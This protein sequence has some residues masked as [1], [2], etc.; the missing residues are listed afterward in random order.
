MACLQM[1]AFIKRTGQRTLRFFLPFSLTGLHLLLSDPLSAQTQNLRTIVVQPG[2][3]VR[4]LAE[5][6]LGDANLWEEILKTNQLRSASEVRS[7]MELKIPYDAVQL[8]KRQL[9]AASQ[10]IERATDAGA[11]VYAADSIQQAILFYDQA[12]AN[13]KSGEWEKSFKLAQAAMNK[14]ENAFQAT[15]ERRNTTGVAVLTD[16]KGTVESRFPTDNLWK[17]APLLSELTESEMV[18]TLSRSFAEVSFH[19]ESR[20]RLNENS[21]AMIEKMRVDL[22]EQKKQSSVTL[23]A[24]NAFALLN[25]NQKRKKFDFAISGVSTKVNSRNFWVQ[26]DEQVT[27]LANY[28]GEI[29]ITSQ[30][31]TVVVGENQGALVAANQKPT[32]PS[33]L[34]PSPSLQSPAN[35]TT[36]FNDQITLTWTAIEGAVNYWVVISR[37]KS[38][39]NVVVNVSSMKDHVFAISLSEE[40]YYYWRV[41]AI[42]R[43]GFPSP[44]SV[45]GFFNMLI[46]RQAPFVQ[47]DQPAE[48]AIFRES[49]VAVTGEVEKGAS[50]SLNGKS[51]PV[52]PE[53]AFNWQHAL[54][55]GVNELNLE[56]KDAAGNVTQQRRRVTYAADAKVA[57]LYDS[58]LKQ[59]RPRHFVVRSSEFTLN[60]STAPLSS[61]TLQ[62]LSTSATMKTFAD[63]S[64]LFQLVIPNVAGRE[65]FVLSAVT[66]AGHTATDS[67]VVDADET[68]PQI[69]LDEALPAV[70]SSDTLRV[71]GTA[72]GAAYLQVNG[73]EIPLVQ[74]KFAESLRLHPGTNRIE[75]EAQ[76]VAGN[77]AALE[78]EIVVDQDPPA[79]MDYKIYLQPAAGENLISVVIKARDASGM[80]RVAKFTLQAGSFIYSGFLKFNPASQAY[81]GTAR[82][83]ASVRDPVQLKSVILEDY[84]GNQKEYLGNSSQNN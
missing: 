49:A 1:S 54:V 69:T 71:R 76:D 56:A 72:L 74:E 28:E 9:E 65:K 80:K 38:F 27:K 30:G 77:T 24:G 50:L 18:R 82:I 61:I 41:A 7:G 29:E 35:N 20:I 44:F 2:Q 83:P 53:G 73:R 78:K 63:K 15:M 55:D 84:Y 59:V 64:G 57:L 48:Q 12:V 25:S 3:N 6:Y 47:W 31:A 58:A 43:L 23:V 68:P 70:L 36:V 52:S 60:A 22:L 39:T 66:P 81:E 13:R 46:D 79:L 67:L 19:D 10:A 14:A 34:L 75:I 4:Q 40:G 33:A 32:T 21:Q 42:D 51:V 62:R 37:D 17:D 16:R 8:A 11:K 5:Q 26:K 45:P